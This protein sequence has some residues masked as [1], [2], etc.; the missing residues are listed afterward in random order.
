MNRL[1]AAVMTAVMLLTIVPSAMVV[2]NGEASLS[3]TNETDDTVTGKTIAVLHT[4]GEI[5]QV[6]IGEEFSLDAGN[7][8]SENFNFE[9]YD[10]GS[11]VTGYFW[12]GTDS[13]MPLGDKV[14]LPSANVDT[15]EYQGDYILAVNT[16][17]TQSL[18]TGTL[19]Q[20]QS[21]INYNLL[22]EPTKEEITQRYVHFPEVFPEKDE[23]RDIDFSIGRFNTPIKVGAKKSFNV[24]DMSKDEQPLYEQEFICK[25]VGE[26]CYIW[27]ANGDV[28]K[29]GYVPSKSSLE[30]I[31]DDVAQSIAE[32]YDKAI[33][34]LLTNNFG[35]MN[36]HDGDEK[37][38]LLFYDIQDGFNY[39][40]QK[41]YIGGYFYSADLHRNG[42]GNCTD[43]LH[44]DTYPLAELVGARATFSTMVHELQHFVNYSWL[45]NNT[46]A[47]DYTHEIWSVF[48][49]AMSM[50]AEH[51]YQGVLENR[52]A[53]YND[54]SYNSNIAGG[55]G[56]LSWGNTLPDY[57]M[58]YLFGQ[59]LRTLTKG[60]DGG[61]TA[62]Y[63]SIMNGLPS[64]DI[65]GV[66]AQV[67]EVMYG[68][69]TEKYMTSS[70][71]VA[72][73]RLALILRDDFGPYGFQGE[74]SFDSLSLPLYS[75]SG[76]ILEPGGAVL[77]ENNG[78]FRPAVSDTNMKFY[79]ITLPQ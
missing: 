30:I 54:D 13:I 39:D 32:G 23:K 20:S 45:E 73:F 26:L 18:S 19:P 40:T 78:D 11:Q 4:N 12:S 70:E 69:E 79:G 42:T 5:K 15:A 33:Y 22:E 34:P 51:I 48:N 75:G 37:I 35:T 55:M 61:G 62:I 2:K 72:N 67:N 14:V 16:S 57:T 58:S 43:M 46:I 64:C 8:Y 17:T 65:D 27:V 1:L 9:N 50:A 56:F 28:D 53:V 10:A 59:Y 74:E 36:D 68:D 44:I 52:L 6:K 41:T 63:K 66:T 25:A 77:I 3:F 31:T 47:S 76:K 71:L 21:L 49:E 7:T 24:V 38:S 60:C 29:D